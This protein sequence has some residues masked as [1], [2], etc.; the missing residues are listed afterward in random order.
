MVHELAKTGIPG[1]DA[2][3]GGGIPRAAI[4]T[5]SGPTGSGK[6]TFGMQ[7]LV[8]GASKYKEPGLFISIEETCAA[9]TGHLKNWKKK[10][11]S[12]CWTIRYTKWTNSFPK[13]V[14]FPK[15]LPRWASSGLLL[16]PSH[17]WPCI[18]PTKTSG[19]RDF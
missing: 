4:V 3:T 13:T 14:P 10:K 19:R 17:R 6:T 1:L 8:E 5:L 2:V 18:S 15:S 9:I 11:N 12:C 16:I 7:F